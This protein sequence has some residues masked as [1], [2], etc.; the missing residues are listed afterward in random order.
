ML[1]RTRWAWGE[2]GD[3]VRSASAQ[4]EMVSGR[5]PPRERDEG[6]G[7]PKSSRRR[8]RGLQAGQSRSPWGRP[9]ARGGVNQH[10][11]KVDEPQ[12]PRHS[13]Q[14]RTHPM[15]PQGQGETWPFS[16]EDQT[17]QGRA[18]LFLSCLPSL[19][20]KTPEL[21]FTLVPKARGILGISVTA[22]SMSAA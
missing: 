4:G 14:E 13:V 6:R 18:T 9:R 10:V 21:R 7:A 15:R 12:T 1:T 2:Q 22:C 3:I 5:G 11:L 17:Q 20:S 8:E 19:S 16:G